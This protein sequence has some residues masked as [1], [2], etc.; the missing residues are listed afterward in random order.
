MKKS[1]GLYIHIPF[2]QKKCDYCNF[3]SFCK[4]DGEKIKYVECLK[5]EIQIQGKTYS[6][7]SYVVDTIFVGGGTPTTLPD[8]EIS[9]I[10]QAIKTSFDVEK[11]AEITIEC[12]PNSLT[13]QKLEEYK[14]VGVNRLSIGLQTYNNKLLKLIGRIHTK[15]QF[16]IAIKNA[17]R[18][19]FDNI[20]VDLILGI[21]NQKI[22]DV[23]RE[24]KH[25]IK[26]KIPHISAYGLIVE[27]NTKLA[28]NIENG[29]YKLPSEQ[30]SVKMY[31]IANKML[32]KN[33][34]YRYEVS[35]FAKSGFEC[36]HNLKYWQDKEYLGLG[37]VS[38]SY[39]DGKRW[40]NTDIIEKYFK[41]FEDTAQNDLSQIVEDMEL[42]TNEEKIEECIMLSL[43]TKDGIDLVDFKNKFGYDLLD[44]K[45]QQIKY[46][47]S[48]NLIEVCDNKL[49]C[50]NLGF[51][52]LNQII[53]ELI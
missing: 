46:L 19:G 12:N 25:L 6:N 31:D 24:I 38:S 51:K 32:S 40:K 23:K 34:I 11:N 7:L 45:Q 44:K 8:G 30:K 41:I 27:E 47:Q 3:V 15:K 22:F 50:T 36:K 48:Q 9:K 53:L 10:L 35:N 18:A 28:K 14:N 13:V 4:S 43:R 42:L 2:C 1:L 33:K 49:F 17:N 39:V 5:K 37:V 20:N 16:D 29:V 21:P 52:L 26:L